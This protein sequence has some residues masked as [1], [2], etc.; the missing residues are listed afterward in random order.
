MGDLQGLDGE[1]AVMAE[2]VAKGGAELLGLPPGQEPKES[3]CVDLGTFLRVMLLEY[4]E[5]QAHRCV[6]ASWR[7]RC[8]RPRALS[9]TDAVHAQPCRYSPDVRHRRRRHC[10]CEEA[11]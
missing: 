7:C 9:P 1:D 4:R 6:L 10:R 5:E 8:V 11:V 3:K 2:L